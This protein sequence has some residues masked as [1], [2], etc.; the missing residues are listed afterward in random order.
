MA[1][2]YQLIIIGGGP[3]GLCSARPGL[4]VLQ[5]KA[6]PDPKIE[7]RWESVV[8]EAKGEKKVTD[9]VLK[10]TQNDT[11]SLLAVDGVFAPIGLVPN[12]KYLRGVSPLD[13]RGY[14]ITTELMET[15][16]PGIL[17]A[18]D[19]HHNSVKQ[20][21][22]AAGDGAVAALSAERFVGSL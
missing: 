2:K 21:I 18:G 5:K 15:T 19:I 20:A 8:I 10:N 14:I 1:K 3:A 6:Q 7:F 13:E 16:V 12:T 9:L 11:I 17:L 22:V 4:K